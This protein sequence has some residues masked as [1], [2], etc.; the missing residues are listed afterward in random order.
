VRVSEAMID[1]R[2]PEN[3]LIIFDW[4]DTLFPTFEYGTQDTN[5]WDAEII[6]SFSRIERAGMNLL[7]LASTMGVVKI[8]TQASIC[9][10][11]GTGRGYM[12]DLYDLITE[13]N[14]EVISARE[15]HEDSPEVDFDDY[16]TREFYSLVHSMIWN[17]G[18]DP[19]DDSALPV[20]VVSIGDGMHE[21]LGAQRLN[22]LIPVD[23]IKIVKF[24]EDP[25]L[26]RL[27]IKLLQCE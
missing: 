13:L 22:S 14:I 1:T 2:L 21:Y 9:W 3:T 8:V 7:L 23:Q 15:N 17:A 12:P 6:A 24:E 5:C 25:T 18:K 19:R 11:R 26:G 16:K 20:S 27:E 4:D 10:Y